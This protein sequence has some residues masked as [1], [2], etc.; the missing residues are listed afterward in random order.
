MV[1]IYILLGI[2]ILFQFAYDLLLFVHDRRVNTRLEK[3]E[4]TLRIKNEIDLE[5]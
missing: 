1:I 4:R 5:D 2:I 3:I